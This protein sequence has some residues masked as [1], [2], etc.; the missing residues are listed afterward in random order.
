MSYSKTNW[1]LATLVAVLLVAVAIEGFYLYRMDKRMTAAEREEFAVTSAASTDD[2]WA[3]LN[4]FFS[5]GKA[6][7]SAPPSI[8]GQANSDPFTEMERMRQEMDR[9]MQQAFSSPGL[10]VGLG[11]PLGFG[12]SFSIGMPDVTMDEDGTH[13]IVK[14]SLPGSKLE[15]LNTTLENDTLTISG[16]RNENAGNLG[17]G[18]SVQQ[19]YSGTFERSFTLPGPTV[20]GSMKADMKDGVLTI[21]IEKAT[22]A[23]R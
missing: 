18:N 2:G 4:D 14:M 11:G 13:Y 21:T 10:Q 7:P 16:T 8:L 17:S 5:R 20:P 15:D 23:A 22:K 1:I 19:S 9:M 3:T 6:T 12:S